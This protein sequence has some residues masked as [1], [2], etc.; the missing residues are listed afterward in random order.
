MKENSMENKR[1]L[2]SSKINMD[3]LTEKSDRVVMGMYDD[4][5]IAARFAESEK[6]DLESNSRISKIMDTE[7]T[8]MFDAKETANIANLGAGANPQKYPLILGNIKSKN[9]KFD[10]VDLS[11]P[12]LEIAKKNA[13]EFNLPKINYIHNDF[14]GYLQ[15]QDNGSLDAV[16]MQYCINYISDLQNFFELLSI[17]LA[18]NGIYIANLGSKTLINFSEASFLI[19]GNEIQGAVDLV[20]GDKY[21]IQFLDDDGKIYATTEKNYFSD[22][23]ITKTV[24]TAGLSPKIIQI[25]K[26]RVLVV[27][28]LNQVIS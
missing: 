14:I 9:W 18:N 16:M 27:Q 19:N 24:G 13:E 15:S 10:W 23:E 7:I 1:Q 5:G 25:E 2:I 26:F 21:T 22:E 3:N 17:K 6:E 8:S 11:V 4:P 12:M 20:H 28:K